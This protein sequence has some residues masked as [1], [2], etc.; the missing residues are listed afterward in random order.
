MDMANGTLLCVREVTTSPEVS[1]LDLPVRAQTQGPLT[2]R[3]YL[4]LTVD[5][6]PMMDTCRSAR[7]DFV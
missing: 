7:M 2:A 4:S 3:T 1:L 6:S 5:R